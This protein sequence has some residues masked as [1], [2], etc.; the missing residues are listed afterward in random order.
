MGIEEDKIDE[1]ITAH[2][3]TVTG[4]K[5]EIDKYKADAEK[6]AGLEKDLAEAKKAMDN[7]DKS[8]YKVKYE[9]LVEEKEELKKQFDDFK[10]DIEAKASLAKKQ[11][12]YRAILKDAGVAEKRIESIMK[13]SDDQIGKIEFDDKG[14]TKDAEAIKKSISEEWADFIQTTT[15]K[16]AQTATPPAGAG[17]E[18][19]LGT[20]DMAS[21]I[22][23]RQKGQV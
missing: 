22:A 4:L 6:V 13:I 11:D 17:S 10:A 21:Y 16:G 7:G 12:A 9:A 5:S 23:A 18:T 19:D 2:S 3:E 15:Q 1:I 14:A 20:L 8:P